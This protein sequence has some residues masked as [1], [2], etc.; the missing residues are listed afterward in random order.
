K[1]RASRSCCTSGVSS[2]RSASC[3]VAL[4]RRAAL[5]APVGSC[6]ARVALP[7]RLPADAK[8]VADL[9]PSPA[10]GACAAD[11][12]PLNLV[13]GPRHASRMAEPVQR[14]TLPV[15]DD[16]DPRLPSATHDAELW[17]ATQL[18]LLSGNP[19]RQ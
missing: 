6:G 13:E 16:A 11:E 18:S 9:R 7:R 15:A 1:Q 10:R 12:L 4:R 14:R 8:R 17:L 5:V 3:C 19:D 2:T